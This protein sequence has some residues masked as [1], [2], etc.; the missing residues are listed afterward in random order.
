MIEHSVPERP[1]SAGRVDTE[2]WGRAS[3][4]RWLGIVALALVVAAVPVAGIDGAESPGRARAH[5]PAGPSRRDAVAI[6]APHSPAV[7]QATDRVGEARA[8]VDEVEQRLVALRIAA[9]EENTRVL[10]IAAGDTLART[11][12]SRYAD[13]AVRALTA[14][15]QDARRELGVAEQQQ[16]Q[17]LADYFAAL[18]AAATAAEEAAHAADD[19][20]ARSTAAAAVVS[21]GS[22][23]S[24]TGSCAGQL[25]CFLACTRSHESD[26]AGGYQA[27]SPDGV[28]RGAYQ[29]DQTTWNSVA[30]SIG[31]ADLVGVN[32]ASAGPADQD[33]LATALYEMRGNQPWG[34]RC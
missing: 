26:T 7:A 16:G 11:R 19:S 6:A 24:P 15:A 31:R 3:M 32:P 30:D 13:V 9:Y 33:T 1:S 12:S 5:L 22:D 17:A 28:Y 23:G 34:G 10:P 21:G 4:P 14:R 27:V 25:A 2:F 20:A 29:F 8:A 18:A